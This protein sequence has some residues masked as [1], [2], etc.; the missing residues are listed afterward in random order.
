MSKETIL[1][2]GKNPPKKLQIVHKDFHQCFYLANEKVLKFICFSKKISIACQNIRYYIYKTYTLIH[3][4]RVTRSLF[5]MLWLLNIIISKCELCMLCNQLLLL[6]KNIP[7][8][9]GISRQNK[10]LSICCFKMLHTQF[11][12]VNSKC[13]GNKGIKKF[14]RMLIF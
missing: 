10:L 4:K 6:K 8:K 3:D 7:P 14:I 2:C 13:E 12:S 5:L 9:Q 11:L 1:A